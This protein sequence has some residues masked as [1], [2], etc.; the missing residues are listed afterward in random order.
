M[1]H[2]RTVNRLSIYTRTTLALNS[3]KAE[4]ALTNHAKYA[5]AKLS[6]H[7]QTKLALNSSKAEYAL[8]NQAG[9]KQQQS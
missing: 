3:S 6:M 9:A 2:Y 1:H 8:T 7:S 4:F 5:A